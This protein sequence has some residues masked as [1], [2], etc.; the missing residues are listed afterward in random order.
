MPVKSNWREE[1]RDRAQGA[2]P[3][4]DL[5]PRRRAAVLA[6]REA[7][8][9][10]ARLCAAA[11]RF[12]A[13]YRPCPLG[14]APEQALRSCLETLAEERREGAAVCPD[15]VYLL[16]VWSGEKP[17]GLEALTADFRGRLPVRA[18][19]C[20]LTA[21]TACAHE[22][23]GRLWLVDPGV[24]GGADALAALLLTGGMD[25][26]LRSGSHGVPI[27]L[28]ATLHSAVERDL[29]RQLRDRLEALTE[30][31]RSG[32]RE[33]F[34]AAFGPTERDLEAVLAG[35]PRLQDLP[36][37]GGDSL[38]ERLNRG[39]GVVRRLG[40]VLR[41]ERDKSGTVTV[42]TLLEELLGRPEGRAPQ[43]WLLERVTPVLPELCRRCIERLELAGRCCRAP[44]RLLTGEAAG[45]ALYFQE[46]ARAEQRNRKAR[47]D[48]A[49]GR[50]ITPRGAHPAQLLAELEEE[51]A[52]WEACVRSAAE[53]AWW[54]E[55]SRFFQAD[56]GLME[57]AR[58]KQEELTRGLTILSAMEL[59]PRRQSGPPGDWREETPA[60]LLAGLYSQAEFTGEDAAVL[61]ES[62][63]RRA[64]RAFRA[65]GL[66]ETVLLWDEESTDL[67]ARSRNAAGQ[68]LFEDRNGV[69]AVRS[70]TGLVRVL[71]VRG[72]GRRIMW[73]LR[74]SARTDG[75]EEG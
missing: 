41:G 1:L 22:G 57:Q 47:L 34:R 43:D 63:R 11:G 35:T 14:D 62:A 66:E 32:A 19:Q 4:G 70:N 7:D 45:L 73:E 54:G 69:L 29:A 55:V 72:L 48:E 17:R 12:R 27:R 24:P 37:T 40:R 39:E 28:Q 46:Q 71:P 38:A 9:T 33:W 20:R 49:L 18:E 59:G 26:P 2:L 5:L 53:A 64:E 67:L 36:I 75:G 25:Q 44:L 61:A 6:W 65:A 68:P 60:T 21:D 42:R 58:A 23:Q 13:L 52:L 3:R 74:L 15:G 31:D 10:A 50:D 16:W 56:S 8:E 30:G 51:L